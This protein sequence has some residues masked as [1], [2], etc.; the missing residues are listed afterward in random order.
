MLSLPAVAAPFA[1]AT[2]VGATRNLTSGEVRDHIVHCGFRLND[3]STR[4]ASPYIA[5]HEPAPVGP[6]GE[7]VWMVI[8]YPDAA[9]ATAAHQ[10]AHRAAEALRGLHL[11]YNFDNGPQLMGG[12]GGSLWR[13]NVVVVQNTIETL[14]SIWTRPGDLGESRLA[15]P[16]LRE[17][18][19]V[20]GPRDVAIDSD[21]VGCVEQLTGDQD[22]IAPPF[23]GPGRPF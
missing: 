19:F 17:L 18:G 3:P 2:G 22:S 6:R 21:F 8:V 12:Y 15:R 11:R 23:I 5:A 13:A 20:G 14:H 9:T 10:N 1:A 7:R 4:P 16:E